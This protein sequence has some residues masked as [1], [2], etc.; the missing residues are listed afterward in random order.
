MNK[1]MEHHV[2]FWLKKERA[3]ESNREIFEEG[4]KALSLSPNIAGSYW[5]RPAKT[6]ERPVTDHSFDYALSLKF[7][8]MESHD[9]YQEGDAV[10]DEFVAT[11]KDWWARVLV[12]DLA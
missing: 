2:Y 7:D 5:G 11:F 12:M 3:D 6:A 4:I 9:R 10:H 1:G 8:S